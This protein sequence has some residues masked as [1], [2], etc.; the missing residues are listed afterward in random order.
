MTEA[1]SSRLGA[2]FEMTLI[3][4]E[5]LRVPAM[6]EEAMGEADRVGVVG[7]CQQRGIVPQCEIRPRGRDANRMLQKLVN[8][9]RRRTPDVGTWAERLAADWLKRERGYSLV[10]ANWR[11]PRDERDELDL[12]CRDGDVLVFVEVKARAAN[13]L[14]PGYYAVDPRKKRVLLRTCRAY[15]ARLRQ[16]PTTYRFDVIEVALPEKPGGAAGV[17][18]FE[19]VPLFGKRERA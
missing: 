10:V 2:G 15:L 18:H 7:Y 11:N 17:L 1:T 13:A 9:L 3:R 14:V 12:I 6:L 19:N 16:P 4:S 8:L 5:R